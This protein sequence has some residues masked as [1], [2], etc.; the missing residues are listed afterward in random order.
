[1]VGPDPQDAVVGGMNRYD[2]L[3]RNIGIGIFIVMLVTSIVLGSDQGS[4]G[5]P[6]QTDTV[7]VFEG[8]L[9]QRATAAQDDDLSQGDTSTITIAE[10]DG[11]VIKNLTAKLSWTDETEPPGRP[12]VRRYENQPD[13]FSLRVTYPDG[14]SSDIQGQNQIGSP[15]ILEVV[16]SLDD[17]YLNTL[18]DVG[19]LGRGVWTI[20]VTLVGA[21]I[22]TPVLGPGVI[23]LTDDGNEFS[24]T[25]DYEYYQLE[26]LEDG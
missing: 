9:L 22:W 12:R 15:G 23:G 3:V 14:N 25:A 18:L 20:E 21:G 16:V 19:R 24:L 13:T 26:L 11:E 7:N 1:M 10:G 6:H 4:S 5:P 2:K 17:E 8:L